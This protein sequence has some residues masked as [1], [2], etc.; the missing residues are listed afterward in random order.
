MKAAAGAFLRRTTPQVLSDFGTGPSGPADDPLW[1]RSGSLAFE[2]VSL[3]VHAELPHAL[4]GVSFAVPGSRA[5]S[6]A[7]RG[8]WL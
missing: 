6:G 2:S 3:R 5:A 7:R 8:V 4:S 1:P